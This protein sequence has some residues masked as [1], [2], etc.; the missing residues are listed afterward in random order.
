MKS[1]VTLL[2]VVLQE[3]GD[4]CAVDTSHDV[5]TIMTRFEGEGLRFVT[6]T[7]PAFGKGLET[8]LAAGSASPSLFPGFR[9]RGSLPVF[10]GGFMDLIFERSSGLLREAPSIEAIR[11]V[12]QITLLLKKIE[13][14]CDPEVTQASYDAYLASDIEVGQWEDN[15]SSDL[16]FAFQRMARLVFSSLFSYLDREVREWRLQPKHGSGATADRKVGNHKYELQ[17]WTERLEDVMPFWRYA[18][19]RGYSQSVYDRVDFKEPG[20]ETPVKVVDVPKTLEARRIIAEEPTEMQY[21]QQGLMAA[22]R[23]GIRGTFLEHLI[24]TEFQE[25]NQLMACQGS[26]DGSLATLDLSEASDRVSNLLV[27]TMLVG[28]P[29]LRAAILACRSTRANVNGEVVPLR[30]FASMGSALTFDVEMIVFLTIV[31]LGYEKAR[32]TRFTD[33]SDVRKLIGSVR[34]YGDDIVV[35]VDTVDEVM[36]A[37]TNYG[38]KVN[39]TKSF[40]TGKFRESCGKDY[41]DGHDVSYVKVRQNLPTSRRDCTEVISAVAFR[42]LAYLQGLWKTA[43]WMDGYISSIIPFPVVSDSSK[44]LGRLSCLGIPPEYEVGGRYQVPLVSGMVPRYRRRFTPIDGDAALMKALHIGEFDGNYLIHSDATL[45]PRGWW[46][47][48]SSDSDHL[49]YS[50]RP[51]ATALYF[52]KARA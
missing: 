36:I 52:R 39:P 34:I 1:L 33:I 9:S 31:L 29:N 17:S 12:R 32:Q 21:A 6:V 26:S 30:R 44:V 25:P 14:E 13:L 22:I 15:S 2:T 19:T 49:T 23:Q 24:G 16:L 4:Y 35:P 43:A 42:N 5:K 7:L 10:L 11:A 27:D 18:T 46:D 8:A 28:W 40:W 51:E 48:V 45:P 47:P 20:R 41:Y 50:G 37:L 38:F 3:E